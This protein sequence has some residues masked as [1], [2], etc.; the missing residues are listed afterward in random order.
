M[1]NERLQDDHRST[2]IAALQRQ[3]ARLDAH[4]A[5]GR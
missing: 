3:A 5:G 1:L 2:V 4:L